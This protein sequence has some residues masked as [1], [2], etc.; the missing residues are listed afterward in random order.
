MIYTA[1]GSSNLLYSSSPTAQGNE[2]IKGF[3][4]AGNDLLNS[5]EFEY[6]IMYGAPSELQN[7]QLST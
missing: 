1:Q 7:G 5:G 3:Y 6:S 4:L 2:G